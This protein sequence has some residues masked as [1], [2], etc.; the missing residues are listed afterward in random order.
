MAIDLTPRQ[1]A[2]VLAQALHENARLELEPRTRPDEPPLCGNLVGREGDRLQVDLHDS[3]A[4]I[5][6]NHLL[7]AYC[8]VRLLLSDQLYLFTTCAVDVIEEHT[9]QRIVLSLPDAMQ[10]VNRR[11]FLRQ[12]LPEPVQVRLWTRLSNAVYVAQMRDVGPEGLSC[13]TVGR[14]LDDA[15]FIGD[16]IRVA[17][18]LP[19]TGESL[20]LPA[21]VCDKC[22]TADKLQLD[23]GL[24]FVM[25]DDDQATLRALDRLRG[26]LLE[27]ALNGDA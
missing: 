8:E 3:G 27:I 19:R 12:E 16:E 25:R 17:F 15:V 4:G 14:E 13:R 10:V 23:L 26:V 9:P 11:K 18:T 24:K 1:A 20:E 7:G 6:L 21:T 22:P 2:R 5:A